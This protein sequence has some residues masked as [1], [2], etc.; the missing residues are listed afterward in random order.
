[1]IQVLTKIFDDKFQVD[2]REI[3]YEFTIHYIGTFGLSGP[4]LLYWLQLGA[5]GLKI[6]VVGVDES[7]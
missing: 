7:L 1:M 3:D 2:D 4:S 6:L 5:V